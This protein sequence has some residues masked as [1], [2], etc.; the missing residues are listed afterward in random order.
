MEKSSCLSQRGFG[1]QGEGFNWREAQEAILD[2][3]LQNIGT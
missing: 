3:I 1:N 2:N